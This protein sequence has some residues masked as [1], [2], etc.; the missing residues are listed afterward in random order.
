MS[1][2]IVWQVVGLVLMGAGGVR[3]EAD[4]PV[5]LSEDFEAGAERWELL[6]PAGWKIAKHD[7]NHGGGSVFSQFI[8]ESAYEPPHRSPWH[9]ALLKEPAVGD[10]QLTA[11]VHSTKADYPHRDACLFFGYQD[12]AHFYYVH[13]GKSMDPNANQIF[14]VDG[15][16]RRKI[17]LTTSDGTPWTDEWHTVRVK[18]TV[19]AG[20]IEVYFDDLETPIM[21]AKDTTFGAGRVG[22]G[23]FDDTADWDDVE[24]LGVK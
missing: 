1:R 2:Q 11:K 18:R 6:D 5:V 17:S 12:S 14:I 8:S 20:G 9:V 24:L 10:F 4:W 7:A 19:K 21:T 22:I 23:S 3:G 15:A 13:F 16:A